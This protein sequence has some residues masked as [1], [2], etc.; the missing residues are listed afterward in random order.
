VKRS[1]IALA[2]LAAAAA[3]VAGIAAACGDAPAKPAETRLLVIDGI[4]IGLAD[5]EPFVTFL[6]SFVPEGGRKTKIQRV[7]DEHLLPLH[8]ARRAFASERAALRE[9]AD[10]LRA[11]AGNARELEQQAALVREQRR[12]NVTRTHIQL[13]VAMWAFDP[14]HV[15]ATS[16]PIEVP[17]GWFVVGLFDLG[18]SPALA[19][20]D[21][22]DLLQVGFVHHGRKS[23][24]EWYGEQQRL[25]ADK[26]TFVHPDYV[27]AM[28]PWIR[29]KKTP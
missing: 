29:P 14:L 22:V 23:L 8:L 11:V 4:E 17:E 19:V 26:A 25:L 6:D 1:R 10:A 15:G 3:T 5:V 13:P 28:P 24:A 9:R 2:V 21:Y 12:S 18:E 7:L 20:N 27:T 16:D